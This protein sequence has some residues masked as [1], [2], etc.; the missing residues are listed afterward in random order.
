MIT[1][2]SFMVWTEAPPFGSFGIL[3]QIWMRPSSLFYYSPIFAKKH[4]DLM[5]K[6]MDLLHL[7][8]TL[9]EKIY[10]II[11]EN[12]S[13]F[14]RKGVFVPVRNYECVI[15]TGSA[16]PIAVKKILYGKREMVIMQKCIAALAKVGHIQQITDGS[17]LFKALLVP[18][19]GTSLRDT[20]IMYPYHESHKNRALGSPECRP[21]QYLITMRIRIQI[22]RT[23]VH[24][25]LG[26][27]YLPHGNLMPLI[28]RTNLLSKPN[29]N[30]VAII[31][32]SIV[33]SIPSNL[34]A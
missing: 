3:N 10:T 1:I 28:L 6:D 17:W 8:P 22:L 2:T 7:D 31:A 30:P 20:Y 11:H 24:V 12:W 13:V 19:L 27:K 18:M 25:E 29:G 5:R 16:R 33:L 14:D 9:Q 21:I 34:I 4:E 26:R 15:N 32:L 23:K